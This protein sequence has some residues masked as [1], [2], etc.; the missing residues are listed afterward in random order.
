MIII[1]NTWIGEDDVKILF[2]HI[3]SNYEYC[4]MTKEEIYSITDMSSIDVM[5]ADTTVIQKIMKTEIFDC[6]PSCFNELYK[7]KIE[8]KEVK[9]LSHSFPYFV[10]P[11]SNDKK[12]D[13]FV[14]ERPS[15]IEYIKKCVDNESY[16]VYVC[17][18]VTFVREFRIFLSHDKVYGIQEYTEFISSQ[19]NS[20]IKPP[21]K[22]INQ[23]IKLNSLGFCVVDIGLTHENE[24]II[25]EVNPP[26]SISSYDFDIDIYV[27]YCINAWKSLDI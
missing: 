1:Q 22:I 27:K 20:N 11:C 18:K 3:K 17:D 2:E 23:I 13:G 7:R 14:F 19:S 16:V 10:K 6:Y 12:F 5:F 9:D 15:D 8:I 24:W 21:E 4:I 25:V 26:F